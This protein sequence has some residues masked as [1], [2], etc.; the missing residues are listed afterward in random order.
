MTQHGFAPGSAAEQCRAV[1]RRAITH[2][3]Q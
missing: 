2:S 3:K 1:P